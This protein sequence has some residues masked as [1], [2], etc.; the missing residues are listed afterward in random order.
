MLKIA[1]FLAI[2]TIVLLFASCGQ[3]NLQLVKFD[4]AKS[5]N[6]LND[7]EPAGKTTFQLGET[8]Y[9]YTQVKGFTTQKDGDKI[10]V[11]PITTVKVR[12]AKG[13]LLM[14]EDVQKEMIE[15]KENSDEL[16]LPAQ[17]TLTGAQGPYRVEVVVED[18][19]TGERL[20]NDIGIILEK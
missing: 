13:K 20:Y 6:G 2:I 4:L 15:L 18:A 3:Q 14:T 5:I 8:I 10:F 11:W 17:I 9:L 12:D 16:M 7:Y 1:K 19:F